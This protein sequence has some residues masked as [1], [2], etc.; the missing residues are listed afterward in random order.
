MWQQFKL[1]TELAALIKSKI[2]SL[3]TMDDSNI[4]A[5][6]T[7]LDESHYCHVG[8]LII[9]KIFFSVTLHHTLHIG[10]LCDVKILG[11]TEI[12]ILAKTC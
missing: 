7:T 11:K 3:K 2:I 6:L 10:V 8:Y 1:S 12:K 9:I 4:E 5:F